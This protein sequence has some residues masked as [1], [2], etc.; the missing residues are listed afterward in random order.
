MASGKMVTV[1]ALVAV[2]LLFAATS[3]TVPATASDPWAK[4]R[5][6]LRI[7]RIEP[8]AP[9]PVTLARTVSPN[10]G[11]AQGSGPVYPIGG[12]PTLTFIYPPQRQQIWYASE[13]SGQKVLWIARPTYRGPVLIRGRQLDGP[14]AL[15]FGRDLN[16]SREM[17]LRSVGG[18]SPGGWQN[19]PSYTRL[20]APGCYAWQV[21][22]TTFSRVIAF[23]AEL[24]Q[25]A[26]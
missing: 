7:P 20:R 21:D 2:F 26:P 4:L 11:Q 15:R 8:G 5:R 22:G 1:K 23:R 18:S 17:R 3:A 25:R 6:P 14:N 10:F 9:C 24:V 13:W 16:P 12:Y 19:R